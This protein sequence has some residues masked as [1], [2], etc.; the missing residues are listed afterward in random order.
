MGKIIAFVG[1]SGAGK[2]TISE[3]LG[4]S[5]IVS[6]TTRLPREGERP[7]YDY[8]FVSFT[9]Y[10]ELRNQGAFAEDVNNYGNYYGIPWSELDR[11]LNA[12]ES[13]FVIVTYEGLE[14][15]K[16]HV[17]EGSV[18]SIFIYAPRESIMH[19]LSQRVKDGKLD[20]DA[21][22]RRFY[23]YYSEIE[24]AQYC[25]F[26]VPSLDGCLDKTIN[27]VKFIIDHCK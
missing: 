18:V 2:T 24:T 20:K 26:I 19:R 10:E 17:P 13:S 5:P 27:T 7:G 6:V 3:N 9:E 25:D 8:N 14:N 1:P 15:L 12:K 4:L 22:M 21:A 16:K 11:A 23:S